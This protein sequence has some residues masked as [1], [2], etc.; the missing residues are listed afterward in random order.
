MKRF[1]KQL[2]ELLATLAVMPVAGLCRVGIWL[3][4]PD[5]GFAGWSQL[6][7]LIPGL[8]GVFLRRA[9]YRLVLPRCGTD[10]CLTFGTPRLQPK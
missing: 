6:F 4:G 5:R 9:F 3:C 2:V 1:L 7:S 8:T 10:C